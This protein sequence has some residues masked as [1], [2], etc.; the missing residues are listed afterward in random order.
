M[1]GTRVDLLGGRARRDDLARAAGYLIEHADD[2]GED[3]ARHLPIM[4]GELNDPEVLNERL[5]HYEKNALEAVEQIE[6]ALIGGAE[7]REEEIVDL[8][9]ATDNLQLAAEEVA[10]YADVDLD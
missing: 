2:P 3:R 7:L 6:R 1:A 10:E 8:I 5:H 4:N 9:L